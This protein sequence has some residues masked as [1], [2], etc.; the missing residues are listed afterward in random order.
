[1]PLLAL[2]MLAEVAVAAA[3]VG[4]ALLVRVDLVW[5]LVAV[6]VAVVLVVLWLLR[7]HRRRPGAE[8]IDLSSAAA[9]GDLR[10][11]RPATREDLHRDTL[12]PTLRV[13]SFDVLRPGAADQLR[14][15][16]VDVRVGH[17]PGG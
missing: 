16:G 8:V 6:I 9:R 2:L 3:V 4:L 15:E 10:V 11:G 5:A 12:R 17:S 1:M 7:P 14:R 13:P